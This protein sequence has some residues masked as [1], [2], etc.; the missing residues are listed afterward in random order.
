MLTFLNKNPNQ[1]L[2]FDQKILNSILSISHNLKLVFLK[3]IQ[4]V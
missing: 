1:P 3:N 4:V 2:M